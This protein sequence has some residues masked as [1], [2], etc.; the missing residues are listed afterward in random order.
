MEPRLDY[1]PHCTHGSVLVTSR[2]QIAAKKIVDPGAVVHVVPMGIDASCQL[3]KKK[4]GSHDG[5]SR[6][7]ELADALGHIPLA[8]A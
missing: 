5:Q 7:P 1:L 8:M 3:I 4:L 2:T 6:I